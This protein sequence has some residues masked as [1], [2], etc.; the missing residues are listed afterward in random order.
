MVVLMV[1]KMDLLT[2]GRMVVSMVVMTVY[3]KVDL[4]GPQL[5]DKWVE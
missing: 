4:K 2:V 5:V 3:Q 1:V